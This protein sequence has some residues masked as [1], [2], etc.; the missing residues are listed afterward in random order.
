MKTA[1]LSPVLDIAIVGAGVSGL[2]SGWRW[3]SSPQGQGGR[4]AVFE[5]S[6]RVG[7]R[8]L[9][10]QPPGMPEARVELGGMRFTTGQTRVAALVD[11]LGLKTEPFVVAQPP[12]MA[13][14]RGQRLRTRDLGD[15][16]KVPYDIPA[17]DREGFTKGFTALA[18]ERYLQEVLHRRHVDLQT[19]DWDEV[20]RTGRYEGHS[21]RDLTMRYIYNR[22]VAHESFQFAED[23]SGYDSIF[24]TW[25]AADGFPWNIGDYGAN[26]SYKRLAEGYEMLPKTLRTRFES[27]GGRVHFEHRLVRFDTVTLDDGDEGVELHLLHQGRPK[28]VRARKLVLAMPRRSIELIEQSGAILGPDQHEVHRLVESVTPIPLFKLALCYRTRWWASLGISQ[29]QSVTD[30]P[31]RQ[32]YYWPVGD[33]TQAGAILVYNDGLDLDYWAGLRGDPARFVNEDDGG[34]NDPAREWR[35]HP[36]PAMMVHEAHRQLLLVH[37]LDDKPEYRPYAA[38]YRDWGDDP[39]GGGANFWPQYVDSQEVSR[40]IVQP[41]QGK[42]VYIC[43]EAYS[44]AQGWVEGALATAEDMLQRHWGLAAPDFMP[45]G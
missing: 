17:A 19:V 38:A 41:V 23:T 27:V 4:V 24:F 18:A 10:A 2:Y 35:E 15:P 14:L 21:V 6:H 32:F 25:N 7:G 44:H 43:G 9:S 11:H 3:L 5:M 30:L 37:G 34:S 13:Y 36:A 40:R 33:D 31:L 42:P 20:A 1:D 29:G 45:A 8:L 16:D 26:I 12:N 39:Y 28:V 22:S